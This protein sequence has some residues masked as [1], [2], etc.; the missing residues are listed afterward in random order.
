MTHP[1]LNWY[2]DAACQEEGSKLWFSQSS[3]DQNHAKFICSLCPV[4]KE[5][6]AYA[7]RFPEMRGI[8]GGYTREERRD[9]KR[10]I[11]EKKRLRLLYGE[12]GE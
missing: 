3:Y 7:M 11:A 6:L 2:E 8:W 5:C 10:R 1:G 9:L 4:R 12:D